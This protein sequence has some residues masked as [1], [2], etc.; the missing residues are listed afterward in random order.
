MKKINYLKDCLIKL[1]LLKNI[2]LSITA[3]FLMKQVRFEL[4]TKLEK[5]SLKRRGIKL[6]VFKRSCIG[7][8]TWVFNLRTLVN[9]DRNKELIDE[10]SSNMEAAQSDWRRIESNAKIN[11]NLITKPLKNKN[12]LKLEIRVLKR[13]TTTN[14][15]CSSKELILFW[16]SSKTLNDKKL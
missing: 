15:S 6:I 16:K 5:E 4:K 12:S 7:F 2:E 9:F 13:E 11:W 10:F 14:K 1:D 3:D 8:K